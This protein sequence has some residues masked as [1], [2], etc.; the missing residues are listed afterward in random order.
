MAVYAL[1][2]HLK[3]EIPQHAITVNAFNPGLMP[4]TGLAND[5]PPLLKFMWNN[6]LTL[7]PIGKTPSESGEALALLVTS[8]DL[9]HKTGLYF[10]GK[11]E[12]SSSQV[13]CDKSK[14]EELWSNSL[15]Y[16]GLSQ[17][18]T[19]VGHTAAEQK[20]GNELHRESEFMLSDLPRAMAAAQPQ[21][22][23]SIQDDSDFVSSISRP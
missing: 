2:Q 16:V 19:L 3:S 18:Y 20:S 17:S 23:S 22:S 1:V 13:S 6:V 7:L 11:N 10:N 8:P 4:G 9:A 14:Q 15:R 5:Y 12:V 21:S